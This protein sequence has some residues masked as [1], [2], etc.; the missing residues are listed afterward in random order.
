MFLQVMNMEEKEKFLEFIYK[1]ANIE[2][3]YAE[4]EQELINSYKNELGVFEIHDT[5]NIEELIDY[6]ATKTVEMKKI[7]L[8]E[9][10]GMIN[11]DDKVASEE[12]ELLNKVTASFGLDNGI[13]QKIKVVAKKLQDVYDEVYDILFD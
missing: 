5:S 9:V 10:I 6:F 7:I 4:E 13:T 8:F 2:G 3:E 12:E 11:A 1:I